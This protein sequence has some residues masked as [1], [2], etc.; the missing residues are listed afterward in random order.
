MKKKQ[1]Q[2]PKL[3]RGK[4]FIIHHKNVH[5]KMLKLRK[6]NNNKNQISKYFLDY[7]LFAFLIVRHVSTIRFH[8][9]L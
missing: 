8:I 3:L 4:K 9:S 2:K 1:K 5:L 6:K 7:F